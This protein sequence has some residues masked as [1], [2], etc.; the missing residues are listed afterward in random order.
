MSY[1]TY[2]LVN[3]DGEIYIGQTSHLDAR[4]AEHNDLGN[5]LTLHTK[6]HE[7]RR[8]PVQQTV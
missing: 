8:K 5:R 2:A 6:R 4:V 1:W 7:G 3:P